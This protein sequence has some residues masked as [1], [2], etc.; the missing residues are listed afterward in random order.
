MGRRGIRFQ[1]TQLGSV[2]ALAGGMADQPK[3]QG[4][5][6][7]QGTSGWGHGEPAKGP[8]ASVDTG[9]PIK[10]WDS[11]QSVACQGGQ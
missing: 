2:V 1:G 8:G 7:T 11:G 9:N 6:Q 3:D 5:Q 10:L 4:H